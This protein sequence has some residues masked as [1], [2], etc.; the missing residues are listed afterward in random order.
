MLTK[1]RKKI[2]KNE[3]NPL[4][5]NKDKK[6]HYDIDGVS[7]D[8]DTVVVAGEPPNKKILKSDVINKPQ[9]LDRKLSHIMNNA[10]DN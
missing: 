1:L 4:L 9:K 6:G 10:G 2:L 7:F 8:G 3:N 5:L